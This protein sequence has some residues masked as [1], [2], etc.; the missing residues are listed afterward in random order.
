MA[1]GCRPYTGGVKGRLGWCHA[2]CLVREVQG[3]DNYVQGIAEA[4]KAVAADL[5][6]TE[7]VWGRLEA[8]IG[9]SAT[10][11]SHSTL[12]TAP[13]FLL[14]YSEPNVRNLRINSR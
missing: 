14:V 10:F 11:S 9:A 7:L 4:I 8:Q 5:A 12:M 2:R 3:I 1:L 6:L 13:L